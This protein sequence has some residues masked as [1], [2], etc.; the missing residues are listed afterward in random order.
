[1]CMKFQ[2]MM[3]AFIQGMFIE[4][5]QEA[6]HRSRLLRAKIHGALTLVQ[7]LLQLHKYPR[8]ELLFSTPT[9]QVTKLRHSHF[10]Q[11]AP[12]SLSWKGTEPAGDLT[13]MLEFQP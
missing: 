11:L 10:K 9:V 8:R 3:Q 2:D 1:M 5:L 13:L 12:G 4:F 7:T 6:G